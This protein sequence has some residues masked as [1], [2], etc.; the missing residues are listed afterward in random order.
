MPKSSR[1]DK[2]PCGAPLPKVGKAC[3]NCGYTWP[4][5]YRPI[6]IDKMADRSA[7]NVDSLT[8]AILQKVADGDTQVVVALAYARLILAERCTDQAADWP[9]INEPILKRWKGTPAL[10]RVKVL[11]WQ[12]AESEWEGR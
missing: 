8:S 10:M 12:I 11:A 7:V 9:R 6:N 2:C 4:P 3:F 5:V 1:K